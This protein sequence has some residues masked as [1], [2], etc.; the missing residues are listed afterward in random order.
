MRADFPELARLDAPL[1]LEFVGS[2]K[3]GAGVLATCGSVQLVHEALD[4]A[5]I[6]DAL[7]VHAVAQVLEHLLVIPIEAQFPCAIVHV[8]QAPGLVPVGKR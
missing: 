8:S 5:L 6:E 7:E 3:F 1:L 4:R 2:I